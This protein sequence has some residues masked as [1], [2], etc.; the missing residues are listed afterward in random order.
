MYQF[1]IDNAKRKL[2]L[3]HFL[4]LASSSHL[5]CTAFSTNAHCQYKHL[6]WIRKVKLQIPLQIV[7]VL[8]AAQCSTTE[9]VNQIHAHL[10]IDTELGCARLGKYWHSFIT[11]SGVLSLSNV[12]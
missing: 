1:Y 6:V 4:P 7:V 10:P 8:S 2:E 5:C 11:C 12:F 9:P 3:Q